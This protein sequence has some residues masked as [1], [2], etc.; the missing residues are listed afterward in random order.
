MKLHGEFVEELPV[1][2]PVKLDPSLL[3]RR[4]GECTTAQQNKRV[5]QARWP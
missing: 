5:M 1:S 3:M 4:G 2:E